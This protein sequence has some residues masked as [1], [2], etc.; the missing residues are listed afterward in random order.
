MDLL[1][2]Q[3]NAHL[4]I[5]DMLSIKRSLELERQQAIWDFKAS[6]HQ[7]EMEAAATN[8]RAKIV[9]LRKDLQAR[10][11]CKK[12]VMRATYDYRATVQEARAIQC[13]KLEEVEA[14]YSEALCKNTAVQSLHCATLHGEHA[15]YMRELEERALEAENMSQ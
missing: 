8:E 4:A 3:A 7:W 9:H 12:A 5:N 11:K 13:I 1:E 14:A 2:L 10:V 15:K 6:L